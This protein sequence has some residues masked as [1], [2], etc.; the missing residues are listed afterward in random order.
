MFLRRSGARQGDMDDSPCP[1]GPLRSGALHSLLMDE[2]LLG[3]EG[4]GCA[5]QLAGS[6]N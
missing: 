5:V 1:L 2:V 3:D 4:H 6:N